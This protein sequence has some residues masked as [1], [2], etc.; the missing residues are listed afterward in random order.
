MK[1]PPPEIENRAGRDETPGADRKRKPLSQGSANSDVP[2]ELRAEWQIEPFDGLRIYIGARGD[3]VVEQT[4]VF[5]R[6]ARIVLCVTAA[7][8]LQAIFPEVIRAADRQ[9]K[10]A[11]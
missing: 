3:I 1:H 11:A 9:R 6:P 7:R 10:A 5:E 4:S 8:D 2:S